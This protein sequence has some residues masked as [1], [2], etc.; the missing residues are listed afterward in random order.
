M[1]IFLTT[2]FADNTDS[3]LRNDQASAQS[4]SSAVKNF[5]IIAIEVESQ[6]TIQQVWIDREGR[7]ASI[8]AWLEKR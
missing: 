4:V 2:D 1:G 6:G 7:A 5:R 8:P 3:E